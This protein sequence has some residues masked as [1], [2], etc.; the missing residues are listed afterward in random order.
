V[1]APR[2]DQVVPL[3]DFQR[4]GLRNELKN[5]MTVPDIQEERAAVDVHAEA[6]PAMTGAFRNQAGIVSGFDGPGELEQ[7][8]DAGLG[9]V[10]MGR[11]PGR[12]EAGVFQ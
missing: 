3:A 9:Q 6:R 7:Q 12:Q 1:I 10:Q 2:D 4:A 5:A 11:R 8:L